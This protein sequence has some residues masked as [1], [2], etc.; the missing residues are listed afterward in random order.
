MMLRIRGVD[1]Y[2]HIC[3]VDKPVLILHGLGLDHL[4]MIGCM[5]PIFRRRKGYK[6]IYIDLPGSGRTRGVNQV[7]SSDDVLSLLLDFVSKILGKEHFI[8]IGYSYG[9]YLAR[10][11]ITKLPDQVDA[12]LLIAPLIIAEHYGRDLPEHKVLIRD[13]ILPR[14]VK[15]REAA[16]FGEVA[17][18]QTAKVWDRFKAEILPG[19]KNADKSFIDRLLRNYSLSLD[20]DGLQKQFFKPTLIILGIYDVSV[21]YK[22]AFNILNVYPKAELTVISRAGHLLHLEHEDLFN[23][24]IHGWLDR[25]ERNNLIKAH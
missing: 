22:D 8:L 15:A 24:L 17:V 4:S 18:L 10:G 1:L 5:E 20:V 9:G 16:W 7:N 19:L 21:G 3:G 14:K 2:Y 6:R 11:V 25:I 13:P 23:R 12:I